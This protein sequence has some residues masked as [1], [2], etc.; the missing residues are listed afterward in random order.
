[1]LNNG[2]QAPVQSAM[3]KHYHPYVDRILSNA[4]EITEEFFP[5]VPPQE[6][7]ADFFLMGGGFRQPVVIPASMNPYPRSGSSRDDYDASD[8]GKGE[9]G[10]SPMGWPNKDHIEVDAIGM[11]FPNNLT[12]R[13]VVDMVG[14]DKMVEVIDVKSQTGEQRKWS[15]SK[16]A[17]YYED[18][19]RSKIYNVISL[20]VSNTPLGHRIQRP[21]IVR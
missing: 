21:K 19:A 8:N 9:R 7:T 6:L 2:S 4:F 18:P 17:D 3:S 5:R 13:K 16:W 10:T 12:V 11:G 14:N 1:M 20:E 15:L